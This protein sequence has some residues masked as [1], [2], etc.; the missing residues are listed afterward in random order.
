MQQDIIQYNQLYTHRTM[1]SDHVRC[2]AYR[3]AI[4]ET[5]K[6][7]DVV[8]DAGAGTGLLSLFAAQAGA[9]KCYAVEATKT[10]NFA[11]QIVE[12][13]QISHCIEVIEGDVTKVELPDKVDVIVSE[14]MGGYGID[15]NLLEPILIARDQW[16]KP[17]GKMIPSLVR[18]FMAPMWHSKIDSSLQF[19]RSNPYGIDLSLIANRTEQEMFLEDHDVKLNTLLASPQQMWQNDTVKDSVEEAGSPF[20]ASL[21]FTVER[22]GKFSALTAWFSAK[23]SDGVTLTNAPGFP[24]THWGCNIFPLSRTRDV[25]P[26]MT[27]EV[28]FTDEPIRGSASNQKWCVRVGNEPWEEHYSLTKSFLESGL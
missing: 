24:V 27:I 19:Y 13:N 3:K 6:P 17:N 10:A 23:L 21:S 2:E 16:L 7:G 12:K 22:P 26:G 11:A 1:L 9:K 8:L 15:E 5:V 28:K 4:F 18:T 14:W 20:H 25:E